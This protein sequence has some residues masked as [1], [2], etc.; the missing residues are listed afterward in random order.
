ML[1]NTEVTEK[2]SGCL[3]NAAETAQ[4]VSGLAAL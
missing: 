2:D 3:N 4:S 1:L